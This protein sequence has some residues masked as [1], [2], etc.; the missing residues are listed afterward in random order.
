MRRIVLLTPYFGKLPKWINLYLETC[1]WN[2]T[3][4]WIIFSDH[5]FKYEEIKNV[6]FVRMTKGEFNILAGDRLKLKVNINNPYKLCDFRPTYGVIFKEYL[7]NYD[8]WGYVDLDILFGDIR[9]FITE[10]LLE[11]YEIISAYKP[12]LSGHF[13]IYKN[14]DMINDLYKESANY[15]EIMEDMKRHHGFA[16]RNF[17]KT[18]KRAAEKKKVNFFG[19]A[20]ALDAKSAGPL[21]YKNIIGLQDHEIEEMKAGEGYWKEGK[22]FRAG[23]NEEMMYLHFHIFKHMWVFFSYIKVRN[24]INRL[25]VNPNG[26]VIHYYSYCEFAPNFIGSYFQKVIRKIDM[27]KR[28]V[29]GSIKKLINLG[30]K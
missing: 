18:V 7:A 22:V 21:F 17:T 6:K 27:L 5:R 9:K 20:F 23:S 11:Q 29:R 2:P 15:K 12:F 1:K 24:K 13:T 30:K 26:F 19:G 16:E 25:E 4:D 3:I 10:D 14:Q 28:L 8:F